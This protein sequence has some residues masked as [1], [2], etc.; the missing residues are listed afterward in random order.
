MG[1]AILCDRASSPI[2][3]GNPSYTRTQV[4]IPNH[5]EQTVKLRDTPI[6]YEAGAGGAGAGAAGA[7]GGGP[8]SGDAPAGALPGDVGFGGGASPFLY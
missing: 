4:V 1:S 7:D 3:T 8:A 5:S 6:A 2:T